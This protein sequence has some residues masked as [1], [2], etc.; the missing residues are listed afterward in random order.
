MILWNATACSFIFTPV[1]T[2]LKI[3]MHSA[4]LTIF[5]RSVVSKRSAVS[6]VCLARLLIC[7]AALAPVIA[8]QTQELTVAKSE[9]DPAPNTELYEGLVLGQ[10]VT[11]A[12]QD[13]YQG[14][15]T[16]WRDKALGSRYLLV[17]RERPSARTG[18]VV[19]VEHQ[20]RRLLQLTLPNSRS[21]IGR[22]C[23]PA[24]E[25]IWQRLVE[26]ELNAKLDADK[27]LARD[28]L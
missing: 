2:G 19:W 5:H 12:G 13:F 23:E 6:P 14:F 18:S 9:Q 11:V 21:M 8:A 10:T 26:T 28:E 3:V 27:D 15:A 17:I 20:G 7:V 4:P 16:L 24:V 25:E 1:S 22:L